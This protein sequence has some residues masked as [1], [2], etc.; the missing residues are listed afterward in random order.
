MSYIVRWWK[1]DE[2]VSEQRFDI[3]QDA[4]LAAA[5]RLRAHKVRHG[6]TSATVSDDDDVFYLRVF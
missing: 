5:Q 6:A 2:V 3:L 4:K 1:D